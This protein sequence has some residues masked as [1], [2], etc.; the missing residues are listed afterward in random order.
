MLRW[1]GALWLERESTLVVA[2]LHFEKGSSYAAR[3]GQM[4]PPYDTRETLDRLDREI[5]LLSPAAD[6]PRRQ[7][8]RRRRRGASGRRRLQTTRRPGLGPRAGLGGGQPRRRRPQGPARRDHRRGRHRGPDPAPRARA[9]R[10]ARRGGRPPAPR[11][12]GHQRPRHDPPPLLRHRRPA[13][14][15]AG[16]RRVH[17]RA[18]HPGRGVLEPVRRA[19]AGG[20]AGTEAGPRGGSQSRCGR[21]R[22]GWRSGWRCRRDRGRRTCRTPAWT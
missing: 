16:L 7:L 21:T 2:D 3:F 18:E 8:P 5:A 1:S 20:R 22:G 12:Q 4:L 17:G 13:A 14:G 11:G 9:R 19:A 10:P 15:A 6:L